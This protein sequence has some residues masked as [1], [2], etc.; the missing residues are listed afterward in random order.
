MDR[1]ILHKAKVGM[2]DNTHSI[3]IHFSGNAPHPFI[4]DPLSSCLSYLDPKYAHGSDVAQIETPERE[5][6]REMASIGH[7]WS[8][9]ELRAVQ[10]RV[11]SLWSAQG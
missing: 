2:T 8:I 10:G 11:K 4:F 3:I 7:F 6:E 1:R 9:Q 5:R